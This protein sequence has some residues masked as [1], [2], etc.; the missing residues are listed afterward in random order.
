M[1]SSSCLLCTH[2]HVTG[3]A[4]NAQP[5]MVGHAGCGIAGLQLSTDAAAETKP[6]LCNVMHLPVREQCTYVG[7]NRLKRQT[8]DK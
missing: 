8:G 4:V 5:N 3:L 7:G 6:H 1:T 2:L